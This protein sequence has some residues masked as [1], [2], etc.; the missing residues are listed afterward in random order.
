MSHVGHYIAAQCQDLRE[1]LATG[2]DLRRALA[3]G[4]PDAAT[5]A[6]GRRWGIID[7]MT[8]REQLAPPAP[9]A[10]VA[11][12]LDVA[13]LRDLSAELERLA[14]AVVVEDRA[15]LAHVG[16]RR[17]YGRLHPP[18]GAPLPD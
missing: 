10:E 9:G 12:T 2:R 18:A 11:G 17:T 7:R 13:E 16:H 5:R 15:L 4:D 3:K 8:A 6:V 14:H 1:I